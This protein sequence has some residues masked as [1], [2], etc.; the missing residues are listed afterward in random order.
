MVS[1]DP[2]GELASVVTITS[3][4]VGVKTSRDDVDGPL[5]IGLIFGK[6]VLKTVLETDIVCYRRRRHDVHR[7]KVKSVLVNVLKKRKP[8]RKSKW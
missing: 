2:G 1:V 5:N 3:T 7:S 8:W 4:A 6:D